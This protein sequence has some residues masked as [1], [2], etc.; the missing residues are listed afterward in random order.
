MKERAEEAV[1]EPRPAALLQQQ[2]ATCAH[3]FFPRRCPG[4]GLGEH[5]V[6][7]ALGVQAVLLLS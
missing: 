6:L 2:G 1:A 3:L 4:H 5:C 7:L